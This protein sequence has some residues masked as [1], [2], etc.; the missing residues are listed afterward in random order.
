MISIGLAGAIVAFLA[1]NI[2]KARS[3]EN[4]NTYYRNMLI[5]TTAWLILT[6]IIYI[7]PSST[8]INHHYKNEPEK[9]RLLNLTLSEP[10]DLEY[11][12]LYDEYKMK[13]DSLKNKSNPNLTD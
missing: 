8:L 10:D 1:T 11:R 9:A 12:K 2:L 6:S 7:I 5:R 13:Q 4:L 3:S